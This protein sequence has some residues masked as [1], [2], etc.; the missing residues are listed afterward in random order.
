MIRSL[1]VVALPAL[2]VPRITARNLYFHGFYCQH[3]CSCPSCQS[4]LWSSCPCMSDVMP[5]RCPIPIKNQYVPSPSLIIIPMNRVG[6]YD[7]TGLLASDSSTS[8][9]ICAM[10]CYLTSTYLLLVIVQNPS[11]SS[12]SPMCRRYNIIV[13]WNTDHPF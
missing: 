9:A 13:F 7:S 3:Y 12:M 5:S 4:C 8:R 11:V 2:V 10:D 1:H 6:F